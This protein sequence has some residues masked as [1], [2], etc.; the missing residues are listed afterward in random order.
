MKGRTYRYTCENILYP[1]GF[2]LTYGDLIAQEIRYEDGKAFVTARNVGK[3]DTEDVIELYIRDMESPFEV[4][5]SRLCGFR[6]IH[7]KAG[8]SGV[9]AL[10]PDGKAFTVVDEDGNR[11]PGS[12]S[13]RLWAGFCSPGERGEQL[14]GHPLVSIDI[15]R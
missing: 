12:G 6:R 5:Q 15:L 13:Y 8:E 3:S 4:P 11:L 1:F 9:F 14:T 7:L 10:E 2:G